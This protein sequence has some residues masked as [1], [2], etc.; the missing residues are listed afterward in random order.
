MAKVA[1][2]TSFKPGK[3]GNPAGRPKTVEIFVEML[4]EKTPRAVERLCE[5]VEQNADRGAAAA[6]A[7]FL[8]ERAYGRAP[9]AVDLNVG[10]Q[11]LHVSVQILDSSGKPRA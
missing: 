4:R 11:G 9:Q 1:G 7:K 2:P 10:G 3:S 5:I 8:I 6:A